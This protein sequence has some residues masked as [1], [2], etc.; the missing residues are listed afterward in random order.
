MAIENESSE[1]NDY[2]EKIALI[3]IN[4]SLN[5][6]PI[7]LYFNLFFSIEMMLSPRAFYHLFLDSSN[8]FYLNSLPPLVMGCDAA[9]GFVCCVV[10]NPRVLSACQPTELI[11]K[12]FHN[13][14]SI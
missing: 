1:L 4:K 5:S 10:I 7:C 14:F 13:F 9:L 6:S 3:I 11:L 12:F 2:E 8:P